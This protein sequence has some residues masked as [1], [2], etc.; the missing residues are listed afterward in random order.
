VQDEP[1]SALLDHPWVRF[2][3]ALGLAELGARA[4]LSLLS[5]GMGALLGEGSPER[6]QILLGA[7]MVVAGAAEGALVGLAESWALRRPW[8]SA[9]T[10]RFV[11]ASAFAFALVWL[12]GTLASGAEPATPSIAMVMLVASAAGAALGAVLGLS[13]S[14]ALGRVRGAWVL[15]N[16]LAWASGML[17]G[18]LITQLVPDGPFTPFVL[19]VEM[20]SGALTGVVVALSIAGSARAQV[21][22]V[23]ASQ[24]NR[25]AQDGLWPGKPL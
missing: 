17:A 24:P 8:R 13:Q 19:G 22:S 3:W 20:L 12:L 21:G 9:S 18:A 11:G 16:G 15:A 2:V 7:T 10:R 25:D 14:L 6:A 4:F 5:T 1:R 23:A